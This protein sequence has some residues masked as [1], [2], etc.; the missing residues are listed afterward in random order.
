MSIVTNAESGT[1]SP[2]AVPHIE[3]SDIFCLGAE[4]PFCLHVDLPDT[5]EPVKEVHHDAAHERLQRLVDIG[6]IYALLQDFLTIH[7]GKNLRHVGNKRRIDSRNFWT[8]PEL[9][10]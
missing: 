6:K 1:I 3:L 8:F 5:P 10:P 7:P 9:P 4:I 2:F